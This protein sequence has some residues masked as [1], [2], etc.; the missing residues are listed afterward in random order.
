[1]IDIMIVTT[2]LMSTKKPKEKFHGGDDDHEDDRRDRRD[3]E[4]HMDAE[5]DAGGSAVSGIVRVLSVFMAVVLVIE[6]LLGVWAAY[7]S[8]TS[9]RLI[10]WGHPWCIVFA[11]IAFFSGAH[12]LFIH[13]IN[14]LDLICAIRKMRPANSMQQQ[15]SGGG[16]AWRRRR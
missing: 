13:L 3:Y 2:Y 1:L 8:Y 5:V 10:D 9:N 15:Q 7:L 16:S 6:L 12:Y 4:R 14:K 11:I